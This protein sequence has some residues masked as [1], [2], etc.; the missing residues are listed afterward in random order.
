MLYIPEMLTAE[1]GEFV[2]MR[3]VGETKEIINS[4]LLPVLDGAVEFPKFPMKIIDLQQANAGALFDVMLGKMT[5]GKGY[6]G[7]E[8]A[9]TGEYQ[10]SPTL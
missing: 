7:G 10:N 6:S 5:T 2:T 8:E 3:F 9:E 4:N 1:A